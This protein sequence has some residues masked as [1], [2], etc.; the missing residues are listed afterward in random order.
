MHGEEVRNANSTSVH[1]TS[2]AFIKQSKIPRVLHFPGIP[3][4][5]FYT[6]T[7]FPNNPAAKDLFLSYVN[8]AHGH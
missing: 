8:E 5:Q 2:S 1:T 6:L 4:S 3:A 7:G